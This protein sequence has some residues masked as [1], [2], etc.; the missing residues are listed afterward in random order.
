MAKVPQ[1]FLF[2]WKEIDA[3]SDLDRL[4]LVLSAIPDE[5]FM[6]KLEKKRGKGRNDYP[7]RPTWNSLLAGVVYQHISSASLLREL[8]RNGELRDL[9]GFDPIRGAVAVPSDDAFG[10]FLAL[11]VRCRADLAVMFDQLLDELAKV[12][13]DLGRNAATDGKAIRSHGKPVTSEEKRQNPDGRRDRDADWG[14]K[15]YRGQKKDGTN[16]EK[17]VKWF[18]YKLHLMV[19]VDYELPL[20]FEVTKA[21]ASDSPRLLPL[22]SQWQARHPEI[23]AR[24]ETLAA[25]KG[26]DSIQNN[27]VTFEEFGIKPVID[28]RS[29]WKDGEKTRPVYPDRVDSFVYNEKGEVYCICPETGEQRLLSPMGFENERRA[30]KYR[31]PAAAGQFVCAGRRSCE[32]NTN[33]GE[34]GRVLRIPLELDRRIFT[35][36]ARPSH[37]WKRL[38][39]GRSA[40]ERV[41][42]RVDRVLGF[43]RH[44]LRGLPK[45]EMRMTLGMVVLLAM[46]LGRIQIGQMEQMRSL[47]QPV[48]RAA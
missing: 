26:Y 33:T 47:V 48:R 21:S 46:A 14:K 40:V 17:I 22:L 38:Y 15:T 34:F 2:G 13:P 16:Y 4:R 43:E 6:R 27:R 7:I 31:C 44:F 1:P 45:I 28:K 29:M 12:L 24:T 41:N 11:V 18:G 36:V 19:D 39:N 23:A 10:R 25:D 5:G 30:L 3:A 37:K 32:K 8:R 9:C 35:P 20:G 42:S